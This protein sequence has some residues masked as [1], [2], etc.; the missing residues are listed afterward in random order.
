MSKSKIMHGGHVKKVKEVKGTQKELD[1]TLR[2]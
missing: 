1:G 2:L